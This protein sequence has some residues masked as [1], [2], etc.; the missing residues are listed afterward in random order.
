MKQLNC[1]GLLAAFLL[2]ASPLAAQSVR[3][4]GVAIK[5]AA[6]D[7]VQYVSAGGNDA[8]G[9]LSA[10]SSK[11]T[12]QA[13]VNALPSGGGTVVIA[14]GYSATITSPITAVNGLTVIG[15]GATLNVTSATS[16]AFDLRNKNNVNITGLDLVGPNATVSGTVPTSGFIIDGGTNHVISHNRMT[17]FLNGVVDMTTGGTNKE[18]SYNTITVCPNN[19]ILLGG[20][21]KLRIVGNFIDQVGTLNMHHGIYISGGTEISIQ[22]NQISNI[23][24]FGIQLNNG[25][26]LRTMEEISISGNN[27]VSSGAATSGARGG[28]YQGANSASSATC[29]KTTIS[30]NTIASL[31]GTD[32]I[33]TDSC[34]D[35]SIRGNV[36]RDLGAAE[37][38]SV[39][40]TFTTKDGVITGN[41]IDGNVG[42]T[43]GIHL[44]SG[45][46]NVA[47]TGNQLDNIVQ[48]GIYIDGAVDSIVSANSLGAV[49]TSAGANSGILLCHT[50]LRNIVFGNRISSTGAGPGIQIASSVDADNIVAANTIIGTASAGVSNSGT[51]NF[52]YGNKINNTSTT[53]DIVP[54][55]TQ[56]DLSGLNANCATQTLTKPSTNGWYRVSAYIDVTKAGGAGATAPQLT[57][58]Y[59]SGDSSTA[60]SV[61]YLASAAGTALGPISG[62]AANNSIFA[63]SGVAV[64]LS[65]SGY[66]AG[67][68]AL[69]YALH[70]R[71][72]GPF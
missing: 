21:K 14:A 5:N 4:Q 47:L 43:N 40:A 61:T 17:G 56:V 48:N 67:T 20:Q 18:I 68:P 57:I 58:G 30:N 15:N 11:L 10:G 33:R 1:L 62:L 28:I 8:N 39:I 12:I 3:D 7:A 45:V 44:Y 38:I 66:V 52:I 35:F 50:A 2:L 25:T 55:A 31:N 53:L 23:T 27:I 22:H 54:V 46:A 36:L 70:A 19:G 60:A 65:C 69:V 29:R 32:G 41:V 26:A 49:N 64:T 16:Y 9:G 42:G 24:G 72:E 59:T 63:K 13:A 51:R 71:L 6:A 34:T 37:G